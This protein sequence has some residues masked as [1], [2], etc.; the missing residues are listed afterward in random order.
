MAI[1]RVGKEVSHILSFSKE[2]R[3]EPL[4]LMSVS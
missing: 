2:L 1:V 4:A 3:V